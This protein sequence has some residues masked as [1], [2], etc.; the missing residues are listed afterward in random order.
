MA[1]KTPVNKKGRKIFWICFFVVYLGVCTYFLF[2]TGDA[3][4]QFKKNG[5]FVWLA[6]FLGVLPD[7]IMHALLF[8]PIV[9]LA[10][11]AVRPGWIVIKIF[12]LW[13]GFIF[14]AITEIIQFYLPY[15]TGDIGD[16]AADI[17]GSVLGIPLLIF[18]YWKEQKSNSL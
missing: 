7:K 11:A 1:G 2:S 13:S 17:V 5:L 8:I 3:L 10:W 15:R 9:P 4:P 14:G 6:S 18:Y 12:I 16:V